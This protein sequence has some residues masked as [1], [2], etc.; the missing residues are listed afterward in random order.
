LSRAGESRGRRPL[1]SDRF[2]PVGDD[3]LRPKAVIA[4]WI[5]LYVGLLDGMGAA[6]LL[7]NQQIAPREAGGA[8]A[9]LTDSE[10]VY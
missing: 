7:R 3:R 9:C 6:R 2:S 4:C 5:R 10:S 1:L 8:L